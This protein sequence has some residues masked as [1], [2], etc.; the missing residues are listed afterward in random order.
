MHSCIEP[1]PRISVVI[2]AL[3]G[4]RSPAVKSLAGGRYGDY[5][6]GMYEGWGKPPSDEQIGGTDRSGAS[7]GASAAPETTDL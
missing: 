4:L 7:A 3:H 5:G 6:D 1:A 2:P